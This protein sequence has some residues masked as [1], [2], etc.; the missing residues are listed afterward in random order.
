MVSGVT[1]GSTPSSYDVAPITTCSGTTAMPWRSTTS[2]GSMAVES[3]TSATVRDMRT[4]YRP[5]SGI[6]A[7]LRGFPWP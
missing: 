2:R 3:V 5:A 6:T 1:S 7:P 4:G